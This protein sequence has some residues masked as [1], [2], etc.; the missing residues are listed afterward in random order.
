[1]DQSTLATLISH[2]RLTGTDSSSV[3]IK[4]SAA[5][6]P[7]SMTE[8]LSAFANGAGGTIILGLD[9]HNGF[10]P[11]PKFR[12]AAIS[13][14]LAGA[15]ANDMTPPVRAAVDI[16]PF[17]GSSLVVAEVPGLAPADKPCYVTRRGRYEGSFARTGDGDRRLTP[18]EVDRLLENRTQPRWDRE[19]VPDAAIT[20]LDPELVAGLL[21]KERS[22][23]PRIFGQRSDT[24][25]LIKLGALAATKDGSVCPTLG[26]LMALGTY[27][28]EF[29]PRLYVSFTLYPGTDKTSSN[30][31]PRFLDNVTLSGPIPYLV[32]E[33]VNRVQANMRVGGII[34]GAFRKDLPDYP[35]VAVREAVTNALMH[36][37]YSP[38]ARGSQVQV[39]MFVDRLEITNPGGLFGP[40]TIESLLD[41][42]LAAPGTRNAIL[43]RLLESTPFPGGGYVAENR[44]SGFQEIERQLENDLLPPA[45]PKDKLTSF[46]LTFQRRLL[47]DAE[48]GAAAGSSSTERILNYLH[49][50]PSATSR[51]LAAAAG[52]GVGGA[53]RIINNLVSEGAVE[54]TEPVTSPKQR[55][56]LPR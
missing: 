19:P 44:G 51:E 20:D 36:R 49:N 34:E 37:D 6:L 53:R 2:A 30:G 39:N 8:T 9:E 33:A 38:E 16:I 50:H 52:I 27:P 3:E 12:A 23:A 31:G 4:A 43:S 17:E 48:R 42:T 54:R 55:Y 56:R 10:L 29:F 47:T 1:M 13:D 35:P 7:K 26:G 18:Y 21:K 41:G 46:S 28:Q 14:A 40:V 45:K 25:A 15:C 24:D 11:V 22:Q 5:K 32:E